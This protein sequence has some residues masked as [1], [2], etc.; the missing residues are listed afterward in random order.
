M[1]NPRSLPP[2]AER[3]KYPSPGAAIA[4]D[5]LV[6]LSL[7]APSGIQLR[8]L[9]RALNTPRSTLHRV[10]QTLE[11]K[12]MVKRVE[13]A[14]YLIGDETRRL[15]SRFRLKELPR[16]A[17]PILDEV[18]RETGE[19]VNLAVAEDD[20]MV[21]VASVHSSER[22]RT[23]TSVGTRDLL[24]ASA[25]GKAYLS[26]LPDEE[27]RRALKGTLA[28][29][30]P[31][32][33]VNRAALLKELTTTRARGFAIDD[34]ESV[35]GVRCVGA[36]IFGEDGAPVGAISVMGPTSRLRLEDVQDISRPLVRAAR[37]LSGLMG[38]SPRPGAG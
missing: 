28:A 27:L 22:L 35:V 37:Q 1:D 11:A 5:V 13:G 38:A 19:S 21:V 29:P 14:G 2:S 6:V 33:I 15:G 18:H 4:A 30:T 23:V 26:A 10:L 25:L 20:A 16:V 12:G 9:A 24:H 7:T 17:A 32:T 31:G 34:E 36:A 8:E 3:R